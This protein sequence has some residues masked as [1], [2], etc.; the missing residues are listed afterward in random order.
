MF[1]F[2]YLLHMFRFSYLLLPLSAQPPQYVAG[3]LSSSIPTGVY[4]MPN[5]SSMGRPDV[6]SGTF[7]VDSHDARV[8]F[9]TGAT[10]LFISLDF[11]RRKNISS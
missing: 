7:T 1:H 2:S 9:D 6:V 5:A 11:A 4:T 8:L 3:G 10:F